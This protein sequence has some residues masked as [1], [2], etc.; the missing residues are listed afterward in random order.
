MSLIPFNN[1]PDNSRLWVFNTDRPLD[2][3]LVELLGTA[4][5]Q[6]LEQ[7]TAH[8]VDLPAGYEIRYNR[9]ILIGA[10]TSH[11][12]PSGC[13]IDG[14][15]GFLRQVQTQFSLTIIDAPDVCYRDDNGVECVTRP[16]FDELAASGEVTTGTI[17]FDGMITTV[18][19]VRSGKWEKPARD[20][21]HVRAY[22][23][24]EEAAKVE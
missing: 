10:D 23:L 15:M 1:L 5:G 6:F 24:K 22:D 20:S 17:V 8:R 21:W 12:G 19:D 18:G 4:V 14:M 3:E 11:T 7:W 16:R 9:F 2:D 13:S